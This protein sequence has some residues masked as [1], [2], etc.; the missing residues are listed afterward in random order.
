[1]GSHALTWSALERV[2]AHAQKGGGL[3]PCVYFTVTRENVGELVA[4]WKMVRAAGA[5]FDF[6]PVNDAPDLYLRAEDAPIWQ[7]AVAEIAAGDAGVAARA[8]YYAEALGYHRGEAGPVRCLGFI[9]QYGVRFDGSLLPCCVWG[10]DGLVAGNV[11]ETP[12]SELWS[13]AEVQGRREKMYSQGCSVGCYN[14]SLYEFGASTGL[15][16][17]VGG[18]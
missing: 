2:V 16:H 10:G 6:W 11:F 1:V 12:L 14:H 3:D 7:A 8:H 15:S 9:D 18:R 13:S 4:V 17:R 5:R